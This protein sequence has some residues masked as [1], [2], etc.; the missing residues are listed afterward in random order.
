MIGELRRFIFRRRTPESAT[1]PR[2]LA[3]ARGLALGALVGAA[4]AGSGLWNRR[5]RR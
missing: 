1:D 4:I 3:F 2:L 5:R